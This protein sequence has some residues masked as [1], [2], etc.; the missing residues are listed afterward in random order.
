MA[1]RDIGCEACGAVLP[2]EISRVKLNKPNVWHPGKLCPMCGAEKFFPIIAITDT[3]TRQ[4]KPV[5]IQRRL[6]LNPWTGIAALVVAIVVVL[7]IFLWPERRGDR[8]EQVPYS[9]GKCEAVF[10]ARKSSSLPAKCTEC[11]ERAGYRA[12]VCTKCSRLYSYGP[13]H[14]PHCKSRS[15]L[16]LKSV[17]DAAQARKAHA[18]YLKLEELEDDEYER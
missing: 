10:L 6:L 15:R 2:M 4:D 17:D 3:D 18:E 5:S 8:G 13:P 11:D 9:C 16:P 14:C 7:G 1:F 12:A